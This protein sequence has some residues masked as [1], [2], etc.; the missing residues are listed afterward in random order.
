MGPSNP[1]RVLEEINDISSPGP[2][3]GQ[4]TTGILQWEA[5][6]DGAKSFVISIKPHSGWEIEK[7][8]NII[9]YDIQGFPANSGSGEASVTGKNFT[10]I[11]RSNEMIPFL[12]SA[13]IILSSSSMSFL[14]SLDS[15][16]MNYI[17][18]YN[19]KFSLYH[20]I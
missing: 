11:V 19:S 12:P 14:N 7:I 15:N 3:G 18:I 5:N 17:K 2:T 1:N 13:N 8:F 4:V 10:V 20:L 9:L 6:E 16:V